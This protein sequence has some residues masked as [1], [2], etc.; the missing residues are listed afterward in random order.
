MLPYI[1]TK[2]PETLSVKSIITVFK[3][4][5]TA[6]NGGSGEA[7]DFPELLYIERGS[8]NMSVNG[9]VHKLCAGDAIIYSPGAPH[10]SAK[11]PE[12]DVFIMGF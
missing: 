3:R 6:T 5:F 4:K 2:I 1:S 7:H 12:A 9:T 11:S 10:F 8:Y